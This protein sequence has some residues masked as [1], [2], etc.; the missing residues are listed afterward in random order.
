MSQ[1]VSTFHLK[2]T[3]Q[4]K[5]H[6]S[7]LYEIFVETWSASRWVFT[8][9]DGGVNADHFVHGFSCCGNAPISFIDSYLPTREQRL[10]LLLTKSTIETTYSPIDFAAF[11]LTIR[12]D[13][14]CLLVKEWWLVELRCQKIWIFLLW[15]FAQSGKTHLEI[16]SLGKFYLSF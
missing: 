11:V 9:R 3:K 10:F 5:Q 15:S 2:R 16:Q 14:V 4:K 8:L 13:D 12:N 6:F 7:N 1:R